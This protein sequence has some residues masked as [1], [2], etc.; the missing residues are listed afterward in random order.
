M[1]KR[2]IKKYL[3]G[4]KVKLL[5]ILAENFFAYHFVKENNV[6]LMESDREEMADKLRKYN[7]VIPSLEKNKKKNGEELKKLVLKRNELNSRAQSYDA[8]EQQL[9]ALQDRV[10][11][12]EFQYKNWPKFEKMLIDRL[13]K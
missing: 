2:F 1:K 7:L 6:E 4:T 10:K 9:K 3:R 11:E 13:T 5:N 8:V 12:A